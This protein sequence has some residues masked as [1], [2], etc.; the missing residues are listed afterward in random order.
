MDWACFGE[1]CAVIFFLLSEGCRP[2]EGSAA[3]STPQ[4]VLLL[5][6]PEQTTRFAA[7]FFS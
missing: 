3:L 5:H 7:F 2:K 1:L 6:I 4:G